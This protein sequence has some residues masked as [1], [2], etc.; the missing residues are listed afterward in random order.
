MNKATKGAVAAGAAALLL[1]GGAGTMAAW[2]A[3][4]PLTGGTITAGYLTLAA[5][6]A[7]VPSWSV[8]NGAT[9]TPNVNIATFAVSPGDTIVYS[10][11]VKL[12]VKGDNLKAKLVADSTTIDGDLAA[13]LS[14]S[15]SVKYNG[16]DL[17]NTPV[18]QL[19]DG[20]T[21][22]VA[23][24]FTFKDPATVDNTSQRET[25]SLAQFNIKL[26]QVIA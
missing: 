17:T 19:D 15:V 11:K 7:A 13:K 12:G 9:T 20:K 4:A 18:T 1:A 26:D 5:D 3:T 22:D 23:V 24:T 16:T 10:G 8:T 25:A 21:V 14:S 2:N 6:P